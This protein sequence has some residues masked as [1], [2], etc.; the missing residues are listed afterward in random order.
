MTLIGAQH[1]RQGRHGRQRTARS[2]PPER[3][4]PLTPLRRCNDRVGLL[5]EELV[6]ARRHGRQAQ[7]LAF[8]ARQRPCLLQEGLQR[9]DAR[10]FQAHPDALHLHVVVPAS[11]G[12][13]GLA[14][15]QAV[16]A[17]PQAHEQIE[18]VGLRA[19]DAQING[20]AVVG[21]LNGA[22][23]V[24]HVPHEAFHGFAIHDG[25]QELRNPP[26]GDPPGGRKHRP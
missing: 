8:T 7:T 9:A 15:A 6:H 22:H 5:L 14:H 19:F 12:L 18:P 25:R 3:G 26:R 10:P 1:L 16:S 4:E 11:D 13:E 2:L 21:D 24:G 17:D 23:V 20:H